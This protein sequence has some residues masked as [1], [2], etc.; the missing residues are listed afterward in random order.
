[1]AT[2]SLL[3]AGI[4]VIEAVSSWGG[5]EGGG[6]AVPGGWCEAGWSYDLR[7]SMSVASAPKSGGL[8][9]PDT[10]KGASNEPPAGRWCSARFAGAAERVGAWMYGLFRIPRGDADL[11][12]GARGGQ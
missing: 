2:K 3:T 12:R 9:A 5:V 4:D 7:A 1:M 6:A 11:L 8:A 10:R